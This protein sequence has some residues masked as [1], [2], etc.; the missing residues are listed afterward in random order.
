[1][2]RIHPGPSLEQAIRGKSRLIRSTLRRQV[3]GLSRSNHLASSRRT[4]QRRSGYS[5]CTS[6][7]RHPVQTSGRSTLRQTMDRAYE[8]LLLATMP[9][10]WM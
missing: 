6:G 1:V 10:D 3:P 2:V 8:A 5:V 7:E 9:V 4:H